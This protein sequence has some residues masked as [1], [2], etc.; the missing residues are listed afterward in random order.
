LA[1][2][3]Q[4]KKYLGL[5]HKFIWFYEVINIETGLD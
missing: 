1:E 4:V 2:L 5:D 3:L